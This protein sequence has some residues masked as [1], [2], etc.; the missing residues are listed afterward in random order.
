M[1]FTVKRTLNSAFWV[2]I[3]VS[4]GLGGVGA[5]IDGIKEIDWIQ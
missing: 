3:I 2:G 5:A 4:F 1:G